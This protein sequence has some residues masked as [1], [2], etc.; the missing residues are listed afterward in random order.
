MFSPALGEVHESPRTRAE[1]CGFWPCHD[2]LAPRLQ[3]TRQAPPLPAQVPGAPVG[4]R[5]RSAPLG[6]GGLWRDP[7]VAV[8]PEGGERQSPGCWAAPGAATRRA[9]LQRAK[10][11]LAVTSARTPAEG[12]AGPRL[13]QGRGRALPLPPVT[14]PPPPGAEVALPPPAKAGAA[15]GPRAP[16]CRYAR[17]G[18]VPS[19]LRCPALPRAVAVVRRAP[20]A[21]S[22]HTR[23]DTSVSS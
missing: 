12:G 23:A 19:A 21:R 8:G 1:S 10:L 20:G 22:R 16:S 13:M 2:F 7:A 5:S 6:A 11:T 4:V 14:H 17:P 3:K 9:P 18:R 15:R